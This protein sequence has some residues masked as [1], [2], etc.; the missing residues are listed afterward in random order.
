MVFL[1]NSHFADKSALGLSPPLGEMADKSKIKLG[2]DNP[3]KPFI[4]KFACESCR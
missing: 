1:S 4:Q 2:P 3:F